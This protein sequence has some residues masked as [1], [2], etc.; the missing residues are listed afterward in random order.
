MRKSKF[1]DA[2]IMG[3]LREVEDGLALANVII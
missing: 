3:I 1:T 2:Q